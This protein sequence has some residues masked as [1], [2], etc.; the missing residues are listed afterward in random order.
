ME[1]AFRDR[2]SR[3][4]DL[5][6]IAAYRAGPLHIDPATRTIAAGAQSEVLEPRVMRVL[7]ALSEMP[8][9]VLSR[10]DLIDLCWDG[11][12]VS[13]SAIN[14]VISLL[15]RALQVLAPDAVRLETITKVGFRI[16]VAD[17]PE[18][19]PGEASAPATPPQPAARAPRMGRRALVGA[20]LAGVLGAAGL[21][22]A[23]H[24][25]LRHQPDP[26]AVD[27]Y[28]RGQLTL[29]TAATGSIRQ[30]IAYYR[31]ALAIDPD[32]ADAWGALAIAY[33]HGSDGFLH[34]PRNSFARAVRTSAA[35]ALALDP[36][37][38]D[39]RMALA[40]LQGDL[41]HWFER[42]A[43]LREIVRDSPGYWF[44]LARLDLLLQ[45]VGRFAEGVDYRRRQI[46]LE[47]TIP[48][49]WSLYA[50]GLHYAGR[51]VEADAALDRAFA[52][53]PANPFLWD[54]RYHVL[55]GSRRFAEAAAFA[56]DI[57]YRPEEMARAAVDRATQVADALASGQ[58]RNAA[59]DAFR[60]MTDVD[61]EDVAMLAP[62]VAALGDTA[63]VFA[64]L[65]ASYFGGTFHRVTLAPPTEVDARQTAV[66]FAP[67]VLALRNDPRHARLLARTGLEDYWRRSGTLP[68]WRRGS[69][70]G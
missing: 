25:R 49:A 30:A 37:Q 9:L 23:W 1:P 61:P 45:D 13:D 32:Y 5:A 12:I 69:I 53:W 7:V 60:A 11:Q 54:M 51:D 36:Q 19:A 52:R 43:Q 62:L 31:Q 16:V 68:D 22:V 15:R 46:A 4:A 28:T 27:L 66:L 56:R 3:S 65:D 24:Q 70:P 63:M 50:R 33:R 14:R 64:M 6:R 40:T 47:P 8:G 2:I 42:E 29:K 58:G 41:G 34:G 18:P 17:A 57:R 55:I 39:A 21:G 44:G 67:A 59:L 38:P 26:R 48:L 10:D 35:R 20:A